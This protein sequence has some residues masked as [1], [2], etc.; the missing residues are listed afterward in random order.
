MQNTDTRTQDFKSLMTRDEVRASRACAEFSRSESTRD[1]VLQA[2]SDDIDM[3][4][5]RI[6][7][8]QTSMSYWKKKIENNTREFTLRC[9][10]HSPPPSCCLPRSRCH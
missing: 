5:R 4:I 10:R 9:E 3:K 8:V 1:A 6:E 2:N 7:K